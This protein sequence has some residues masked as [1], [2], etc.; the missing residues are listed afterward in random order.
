ME[1]PRKEVLGSMRVLGMQHRCRE[2][3]VGRWRLGMISAENIREY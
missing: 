2:V 3:K 1:V